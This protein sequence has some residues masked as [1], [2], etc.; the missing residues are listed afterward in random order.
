[1]VYQGQPGQTA[2]TKALVSGPSGDALVVELCTSV[3]VQQDP[4]V[5]EALLEGRL[6]TVRQPG[7]EPL[8]LAACVVVHDEE[9]R[10]MALVVPDALRH[11]EI[12]RRVELLRQIAADGSPAPAYVRD[13][14]VVFGVAELEDAR[15]RRMVALSASPAPV[16]HT[17]PSPE[18]V[19][20]LERLRGE[21][22][23]ARAELDR[24]R[25][26]LER[27][28]VRIEARALEASSA[29]GAAQQNRERA[30]SERADLD[31][32]RLEVERDRAAVADE[33]RQLDELRERL[34][35]EKHQLGEV[36]ARLDRE[37]LRMEEIEA[38]IVSERFDLEEA[39]KTLLE[40]RQ[41]LDRDRLALEG[42]KLN[43]EE[44]E[45]RLEQQGHL[46]NEPK[47]K[48]QVVSED[49]FIEIF[50]EEAIADEVA[51][52]EPTQITALPDLGDEAIP[53]KFAGEAP[54]LA[55]ANG[56]VVGMAVVEARRLDALLAH[57]T[58]MV[59]HAE[60]QGYPL[61]AVLVA[62]VGEDQQLVDSIGWTLDEGSDEGRALLDALQGKC[63]IR[64][65][66][67]DPRTRA[68]LKTVEL[69]RPLERN[70]AWGRERAQRFLKNPRKATG[71]FEQASKVYRSPEH[72]RLDSMRHNFVDDSF[73]RINSPAEAKLAAGI[74][75]FWSREDQL[76]QL[77]GNRSFPLTTFETIQRRTLEG[78]MEWGVYL[79]A[80]LRRF[81]MEHDMC[82]AQSTLVRRLMANFAEVVVG[83]KPHNDLDPLAEWENWDALLGLAEDLGVQPDAEVVELA[84][85]SLK[86]AREYQESTGVFES[87]LP[88]EDDEAE[89]I[90]AAEVVEDAPKK[91]GLAS[92]PKLPRP[93][94]APPAPPAAPKAAA[95][96]AE[97]DDVEEIEEFEEIDGEEI[98][99][100]VSEATGVTYFLP[101][102]ELGG[103][104]DDLNSRERDDL[105]IAL[106][107]ARARLEAAQVAIERFGA[108]VV[109][110]VLIAS[111]EMTAGEV[112]SLARFV[113]ERAAGMEDALTRALKSGG[114]STTYITARA[115][116][117]VKHAPAAEPLL[118]AL[119]DPQRSGNAR[120]LIGVITRFGEGL[121]KPLL[122]AL[123]T[124]DV[125]PNL[126]ELL[127]ALERRHEG[128]L[129]VF[130][131]DRNRQVRQAAR[132][133]RRLLK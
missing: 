114:P 61:V 70:I 78:A 23:D 85:G 93:P 104:F 52:A 98:V 109:E 127:V 75:G 123:R 34:E 47:E 18:E 25:A 62:R 94:V 59:Q 36:S 83:L 64:F 12:S 86:R 100:R 101:D 125:P 87:P 46:D 126:L 82:D 131:A 51:A 79:D 71:T 122:N 69:A 105:L 30:S 106:N 10:H 73:A 48:T 26:E 90:E 121:H 63:A 92:L 77:I 54:T 68:L 128:T 6:H 9:L 89:E 99:A 8:V 66:F 11:E 133:A 32:L 97:D 22:R 44:K 38:Q 65:G 4:E 132:D 96:A 72:E 130:A 110:E 20:E 40:D 41:A 43:L 14:D 16:V 116:A 49:Q 17:G 31:Q 108:E 39:R 84:Q 67:Y 56:E 91:P 37:R 53:P 33:R 19:A 42:Q 76:A 28:R 117:R 103:R 124:S 118:E 55:L 1:M 15:A 120:A 57:P 3:N 119:V 111:E 107:D 95:S 112:A 5:F 45:L 60:V 35:V 50:G 74:V 7:H 58:L 80:S 115:L 81:A 88:P 113:E 129:E 27:E 24:E 21:F 29:A 102:A 2:Y 13:F